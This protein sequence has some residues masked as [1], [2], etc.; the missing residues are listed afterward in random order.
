MKQRSNPKKPSHSGSLA[1]D[2]PWCRGG[3]ATV[4]M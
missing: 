4:A 3:G 2:K 1:A